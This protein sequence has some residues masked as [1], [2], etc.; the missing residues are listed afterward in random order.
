MIDTSRLQHAL[1]NIFSD[2]FSVSVMTN[3]QARLSDV[4]LVLV[5][6]KDIAGN[7]FL[8]TCRLAVHASHSFLVIPKVS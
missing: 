8:G 3:D 4:S 1:L 5:I 7:N 6:C 2:F